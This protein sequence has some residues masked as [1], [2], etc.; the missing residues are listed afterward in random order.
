VATNSGFRI[1]IVDDDK[2]AGRLF[3]EMMKGL[4]RACELYFVG[5]G[6]EALHFLRRRGEYADAPSPNLILLDLNMPRLG[7]LETLSA[8]KNDPEL[9]VIP[10]IILSS[11]SAPDDIR[12]SYLLH[13]NCYVQKPSSLDR[14]EK[15][16]QAVQAFWIDFALLP[17][18]VRSS[19]IKDTRRDTAF[20]VRSGSEEAKRG[21]PIADRIAEVSERKMDGVES[22]SEVPI[23]Q[24]AGCPEHSRLLR[25]FGIAVRELLNLHEEQFRAIVDGDTECHRFDLLIHMANEAK[26]L[27][28]Y[29]Y[30]RHVEAHG[31]TEFYADKA[32]A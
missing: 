19:Q 32:R 2:A 4:D 27:A 31:C 26:Q 9:A 25:E 3:Q 23:G 17:E 11:S 24:A 12:R 14:S 29:N 21:W 15:L 7:G 22:Q 20:A 1:L 8:I 16:A 18:N 13:A 30:M 5:D 6:V 28:K 10:V